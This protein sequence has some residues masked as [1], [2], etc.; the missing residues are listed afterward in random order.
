M[1]EVYDDIRH[2]TKEEVKASLRKMRRDSFFDFL[3]GFGAF[4]ILAPLFIA[5]F[6]ILPTVVVIG[7]AF[8][9]GAFVYWLTTMMWL[10]VL[11]GV[12]FG[13]FLSGTWI[14]FSDEYLGF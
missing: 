8:L 6:F 11:T 4:L 13:L 12:I 5:V 7:I 10:A 2:E 14:W 1:C 9:A 3:K